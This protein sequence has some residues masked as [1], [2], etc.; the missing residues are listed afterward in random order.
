MPSRMVDNPRRISVLSLN[1]MQQLYT[2][3]IPFGIYSVKQFL[4]IANRPVTGHHVAVTVHMF[5]YTSKTIRT[6][7]SASLFKIMSS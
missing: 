5:L 1:E 6:T 2:Y 3:S 4:S 7:K